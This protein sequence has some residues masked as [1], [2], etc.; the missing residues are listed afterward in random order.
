[1]ATVPAAAHPALVVDAALTH[2]FIE[3]LV[4]D[5]S[6]C[7]VEQL[8]QVY[9]ALM[10]VVWKTRGIW[11]RVA[12]L[13]RVKEVTIECLEDMRDCQDFGPRSMEV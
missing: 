5:T 3:D 7:S 6:A 4:E 2:S 12:V 10:G 13:K 1:M 11:D 9:S 8:E